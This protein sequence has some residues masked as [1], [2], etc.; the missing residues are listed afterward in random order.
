MG[1]ARGGLEHEGRL[2]DPGLAPYQDERTRDEPTAEHPIDVAQSDRQARDGCL[3]GVGK[4]DR[5][6][7]PTPHPWFG[8]TRSRPIVNDRLDETVPTAAGSALPFPAQE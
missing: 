2:A 1:E 7:G 5:R 3:A 6:T 8:S 4:G